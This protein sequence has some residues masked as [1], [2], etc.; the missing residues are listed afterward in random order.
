MHKT[1]NKQ[2]QTEVIRVS[3]TCNLRL[4][5]K[6]RKSQKFLGNDSNVSSIY[7]ARK[8]LIMLDLGCFGWL[9]TCKC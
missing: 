6:W 2:Q 5:K 8:W 9:D 1:T 3:A 7:R 4:R